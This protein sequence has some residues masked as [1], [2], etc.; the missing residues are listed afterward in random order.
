MGEN[1]REA[2]KKGL[3]ERDA[4]LVSM[5]NSK[6]DK[7]SSNI[8]ESSSHGDYPYS[9]RLDLDHEMLEKL[10]I[11]KMPKHGAPVTIHAK[12]KVHRTSEDT[13]SDGKTRRSMTVQMTHMKVK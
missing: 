11:D 12:G 5:K 2:K 13:N 9:S 3:S 8:A 1:V 10:G 7:K 4:V 6:K